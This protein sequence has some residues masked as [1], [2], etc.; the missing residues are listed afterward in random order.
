MRL[1][2]RAGC[3]AALALVLLVPGC[4]MVPTRPPVAHPEQVW[5][6]RLKAMDAID[7]W[8]VR[9]RL[10]VKT[11]KRGDTLNIYWRR[12]GNHHNISLYGPLG[13]GGV[14][15]TQDD[16]GAT[17]VDSKEKVYHDDSAEKLLY[18]VAG[19]RVPFGSMQHWMLGVAAPGAP[20]EK[21]LDD[22]GRALT[23]TQ[24]GWYIQ[25][26]EYHYTDGRDL[27]RKLVITALPGTE[28]VVGGKPGENENIQVKALLQHWDKLGN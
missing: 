8:E 12:Q 17:L 23:I 7:A 19:W 3:C 1:G 13:S 16:Q 2:R 9:G 28:H 11:N 18:R 21:T 5:E 15:L 10:A 20:Y 14:K 27:P 25:F 22:W 4:A 24:N 6:Q 26:L